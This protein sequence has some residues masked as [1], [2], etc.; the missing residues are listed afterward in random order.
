METL[1]MKPEYKI[2]EHEVT[3]D[4]RI[5][6]SSQYNN[7]NANNVIVADGITVRLFGTVRGKM[8]IGKEARVYFHGSIPGLVENQGG[9]LFKY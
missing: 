1:L 4:V 3:G 8:I 9:E 7:I 2:L 5:T 6:E